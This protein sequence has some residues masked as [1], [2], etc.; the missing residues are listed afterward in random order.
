MGTSRI[1]KVC[2]LIEFFRA[3]ELEADIV[4]FRIT[5]KSCYFSIALMIASKSALKE[6]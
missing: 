1:K 2:R 5:L 6:T 3:V 4:R